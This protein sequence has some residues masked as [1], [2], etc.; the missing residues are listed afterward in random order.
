[1]S[2]KNDITGDTII[3]KISN[4]N[5]EDGYDRIFGKSKCLECDGTGYVEYPILKIDYTTM[6][7]TCPECNG[8]GKKK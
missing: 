7:F 1:M 6:D 8:T 4:K 5:Y 2:N 3:S